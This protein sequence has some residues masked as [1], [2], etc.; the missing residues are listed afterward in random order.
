MSGKKP[1][2]AANLIILVLALAVLGGVAGGGF[3]AYNKFLKKS[4]TEGP[5]TPAVAGETDTGG[6]ETTDA[7]GTG[8]VDIADAGTVDIADT[9]TT[10]PGET[11]TVDIGDAGTV[12]IAD[13]GTTDTGSPGTVDITDTGTADTGSPGTVDITD[14]GTT[15][16]G[17]PGTVDIAE[18]GATD[19]P[20]PPRTEE[21]KMI[22]YALDSPEGKALLADALRRVDETPGKS[23]KE[24]GLAKKGLREATRIGKIATVYFETEGS[25]I[26]AGEGARISK[27]LQQPEVKGMTRNAKASCFVLGFADKTGSAAFNKA[28]SMKRAQAVVADIKSKGIKL[29]TTPI[30]IG[31]SELVDKE[32]Q[33]KNRAAEIW[34]II[35]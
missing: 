9:G 5:A 12:D 3:W 26:S 4:P 30:A 8:A 16:T 34:I 28:L 35:P 18:T 13:A 15:D 23:D 24:K 33:G 21:P 20:P 7:G 29:S 25:K 11:G 31:P 14:T 22:G 10:D 6:T 19:P 32:N 27:V 1:S 2:T 17:S